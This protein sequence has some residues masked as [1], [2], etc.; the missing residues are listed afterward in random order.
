MSPEW[1]CPQDKRHHTTQFAMIRRSL[2]V[3]LDIDGVLLRGK[4]ALPG[5]SHALERLTV[6]GI[7]WLCLTNGGG[8]PEAVKARE[9]SKIL[10]VPI[11]EDQV[12][13]CSTPLKAKAHDFAHKRVLV[14]GC[15]DVV[16]VARSYGFQEIVTPR[17][18]AEDD[19]SRYPFTAWEHHSLAESLFDRPVE[20]VFVLHDPVDWSV[21]IQIALDCLRG[22]TPLG[23]GLA[24]AIPLFHANPDLVFAG[25]NAAPRLACGAFKVALEALFR[26]LTGQDLQSTVVGKPMQVTYDFARY[27]LARQRESSDTSNVHVVFSGAE[28]ESPPFDEL[29]MV[30]DN[31]AADIRGATLAGRPWNSLLVR[32]G[33]FRGD[34]NDA[35]DPADVVVQDVS[36]AVDHILA[37][38]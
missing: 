31:P 33:V 11:R 35:R 7:P 15:R 5:A 2:G 29:F 37:R 20:A 17:M 13:I 1:L 12:I 14:L 8:V 32:T 4:H 18:L 26:E 16:G 10:Q 30:G 28:V 9:V 34:H 27:L 36:E 25:T 38:L 19:P 23:T 6:H 22:G 24:Q 3:A 21:D